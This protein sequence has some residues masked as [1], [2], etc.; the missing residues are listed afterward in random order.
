MKKC[1]C[2]LVVQERDAFYPR[3]D[4]PKGLSSQCKECQ[5]VKARAWALAHPESVARKLQTQREWKIRNAAS[6]Q[7]RQRKAWNKIEYGLTAEDTARLWEQ[8]NG[9]CAI[10]QCELDQKYHIDH[11]HGT[12]VVRGLLCRSCNLGLGFFRDSEARLLLAVQYLEQS[13]AVV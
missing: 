12:E 1:S 8:Q 7:E 10:C 5:R 11:D 6:S 9:R 2:C 4:G 3:K 13:R